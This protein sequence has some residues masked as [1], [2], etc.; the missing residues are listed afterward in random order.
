MKK[1]SML[2][3]VLCLILIVYKI[4]SKPESVETALYT[5][6]SLSIGVVGDAPSVRE[7]NIHFKKL[8]LDQMRELT[9]S[10]DL[11]AVFIRKG[12]FHEAADQEYAKVYQEAG[13]PFFFIDTHKTCTPFINEDLSYEDVPDLSMEY[14]AGYYQS[15]EKYQRWGF[16]LYNDIVNEANI[17]DVYSRIFMMIESV[18]EGSSI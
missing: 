14:A 16:G 3:L 5:G 18:H 10:S 9:P 7:P 13:I 8:S 4:E 2:L 15:G 12:H 1:L 6:K 17:R 11:D